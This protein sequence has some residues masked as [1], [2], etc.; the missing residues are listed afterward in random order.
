MSTI[1]KILYALAGLLILGCLVILIYSSIDRAPADDT[2]SVTASASTSST[3]VDKLEGIVDDANDKLADAKDDL[4][5][6]VNDYVEQ[7]E[8]NS[9]SSAN[10]GNNVT[11]AEIVKQQ[12]EMDEESYR[13]ALGINSASS[14]SAS[15]EGEKKTPVYLYAVNKNDKKIHKIDC[16]MLPGKN[17]LLYYETIEDA[18]KDGYSDRCNVCNP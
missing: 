14:T 3:I 6:A 16:M 12:Q 5:Q 7:K 9:A 4:K 8:E 10:A 2:G 11:Y 18:V 1:R 15:T 17:Y 13:R